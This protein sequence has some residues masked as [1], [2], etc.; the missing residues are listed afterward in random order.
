MICGGCHDKLQ[1][2]IREY[3]HVAQE[4]L[5]KHGVDPTK[6]N[7]PKGGETPAAF[8]LLPVVSNEFK[9]MERKK[10]NGED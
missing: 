1:A 10:T 8:A 9:K 2:A 5:A 3:E 6:L 7:G 4:L